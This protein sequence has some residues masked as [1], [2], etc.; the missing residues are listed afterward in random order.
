MA[1]LLLPGALSFDFCYDLDLCSQGQ[2]VRVFFHPNGFF[3]NFVKSTSRILIK[4]VRKLHRQVAHD[5]II[6]DLI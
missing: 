2:A 6:V 1:C 5:L 4:R 3:P